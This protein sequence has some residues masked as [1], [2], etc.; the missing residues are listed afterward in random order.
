[1]MNLNTNDTNSI[2]SNDRYPGIRPF[3]DSDIDREL[4][5]GRGY[6]KEVLLHQVL[7]DKLVVLYSKSGLGKTSLINA[8]LNQEL[9]LMGF[10]PLGIRLNNP[11][12]A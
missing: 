8:G 10:I 9:R 11:D 12:E 2:N 7:A 5:F 1:M 3:A 4:F 6:E